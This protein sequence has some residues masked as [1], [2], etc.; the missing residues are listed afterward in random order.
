MLYEYNFNFMLFE[1]SF[2]FMLF[3]LVI[4]YVICSNNSSKWTFSVNHQNFGRFPKRWSLV[5]Y[6]LGQKRL[7]NAS[8]WLKK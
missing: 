8:D 7:L 2:V 6:S 1:T 4:C 3:A 5:G